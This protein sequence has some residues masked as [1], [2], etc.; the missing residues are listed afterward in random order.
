MDRDISW[1]TIPN[2]TSIGEPPGTTIPDSRPRIFLFLYRPATA[3]NEF[4]PV[5]D[6][7]PIPRLDTL[8]FNRVERNSQEVALKINLYLS[9][10]D[11]IYRFLDVSEWTS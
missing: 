6:G 8:G 7:P 1:H 3:R 11:I 5:R 4:D 9:G 2:D 10:F